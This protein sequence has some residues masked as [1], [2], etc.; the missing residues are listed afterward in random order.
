M[1]SFQM[2]HHIFKLT[3]W[4][5]FFIGLFSGVFAAAI[6]IN[7]A[8]IFAE[9]PPKQVVILSIRWLGGLSWINEYQTLLTGIAAVVAAFISVA[10]IRQQIDQTAQIERDRIEGRK[11]SARAMLPLALSKICQ[12][13]EESGQVVHLLM[14]HV[15]E[16]QVVIPNPRPVIP[17]IPEEALT[18]LR[19]LVEHSS[20]SERRYYFKLISALQ[21][22]NSR[23]S[24]ILYDIQGHGSLVPTALNFYAL[25]AAEVY[26]YASGLYEY[27]RDWD[28]TVPSGITESEMETA[29]HL[30]GFWAEEG[31]ELFNQARR[32][33]ASGRYGS[34]D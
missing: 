24:G 9:L 7:I 8:C 28:K 22:Q 29:I 19:D 14:R 17:T 15:Q 16:E 25:D 31:D 30:V 3:R 32:L 34:S 20:Q 21:V 11:F 23:L 10:H 1:H 4:Q 18:V 5:Q 27:A 33:F 12:Y 26:A 13:A 2:F 6:A